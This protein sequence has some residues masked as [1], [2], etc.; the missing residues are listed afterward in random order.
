MRQFVF[1]TLCV[2]FAVAVFAGLGV[3]AHGPDIAYQAMTTP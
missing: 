2:A 1:A 3:A